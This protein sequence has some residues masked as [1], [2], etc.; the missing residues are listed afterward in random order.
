MNTYEKQQWANYPDEST[1]ISAERL[2]HIENGIYDTDVKTNKLSEMTIDGVFE[3]KINYDTS[4]DNYLYLA[5]KNNNY[6]G[7]WEIVPYITDYLTSEDCLFPYEIFNSYNESIIDLS[8]YEQIDSTGWVITGWAYSE[9][10]PVSNRV[11]NNNYEVV[12]VFE[13]I[14]SSGKAQLAMLYN[15]D[16]SRYEY[17]LSKRSDYYV[18]HFRQNNGKGTYVLNA[19]VSANNDVSYAWKKEAGSSIEF[20]INN[21][22][23]GDVLSYDAENSKWINKH[24]SNAEGGSY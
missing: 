20:E 8:D 16:R 15:K 5:N 9:G 14:S 23:D 3:K 4:V 12:K 2:T 13:R 7:S 6:E 24:I 1:P 11:I 19:I 10:V 22:T 17:A 18:A 21:P